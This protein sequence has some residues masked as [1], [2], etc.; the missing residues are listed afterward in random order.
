MCNYT[1]CTYENV[2]D[3]DYCIFHLKDDE[4]DIVEFNSQ[5]NQIIDSDGK[6]NF[7]GFYF[8]PGTGNFESAIFKGEVDFKF[9]N[10]CGDITDF[11]R[12]RFCQNVNFTSAKFQKVDFS[13]AK[14][15]K[16]AVFLKVEFLENA[17]F[18]FT[19]FSGNVGFQDAKFKKANFKDSKFL[20][21]AAFQNTEFNEVDFSDVTFDGK[22]VLITEKSPIIHLDRATFSN[23]VRIRAGLQ[24]CSF[25]GSNIERVDLTSC[26][27]TSDEEKEI[28]ILE[29]KNN[30]GYG[31]LVEIY[32]LLRQ[33]CQR[34]GD[35]FTAGEF[36]YQEMDCMR[37]QK[38]GV[39]K[40]IWYFIYKKACGYGERPR[41]VIWT[42]ALIIIIF[43]FVYFYNGIMYIEKGIEIPIDHQFF[44]LN[45]LFIFISEFD[46]LAFPIIKDFFWCF[47]TS[48]ITFTTLGY[49][50]VHPVGFW[51]RLAASIESL[52]GISMTAILIFVLS[53]KMFR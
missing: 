18:N 7:N 12:T 13:N 50:D 36:F 46:N 42:S 52:I 21:N 2:P 5:I 31:K 22:M 53:R 34:Y 23:D 19:K 9:A 38:K 3:S 6:I 14:F 37:K 30:L 17:N 4:K 25:Y 41:M 32:R 43:A 51:S 10:F 28:K 45:S 49:G 40:F 24:N 35:H 29:H 15:C 11:T 33:S 47:Y 44:D 39:Q 8:P 27:W 16:D 48:I 26:G 1:K 20:K